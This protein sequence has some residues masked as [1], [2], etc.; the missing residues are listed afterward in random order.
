MS[1]FAV[2]MISS[3]LGSIGFAILFRLHPKKLWSIALLSGGCYGI[4]YLFAAVFGTNAFVA[5]LIS[6]AFVAAS[7]EFFS[8]IMRSPT[9]IFIIPSIIPIVPGG[10]L[11]RF[12]K[13]LI[14]GNSDIA[15]GHGKEAL[16]TALG[17]AGGIIV[18]S[19]IANV[20]K[21]IIEKISLKKEK[22]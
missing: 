11:Y 19:I 6:T 7:A 13:E 14:N 9:I 17:V 1:V 3:I 2:Q 12:M 5:A 21:G 4:Y 16:L 22:T 20:T 8:R 18:I 10:A 15:M